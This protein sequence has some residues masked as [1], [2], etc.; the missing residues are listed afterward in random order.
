MC[1]SEESRI[2]QYCRA[3]SA[4]AAA[5]TGKNWKPTSTMCLEATNMGIMILNYG[6]IYTYIMIVNNRLRLMI[7]DDLSSSPQMVALALVTSIQTHG[8][9]VGWLDNTTTCARGAR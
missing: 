4:D 7:H 9:N 1:L 2:M 6:Y 3:S 8:T 5:I